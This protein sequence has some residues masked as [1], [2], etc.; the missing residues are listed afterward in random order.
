[1]FMTKKLIFNNKEYLSVPV[2]ATNNRKSLIINWR[3]IIN[4]V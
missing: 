2:L 3:R 4:N 1:M